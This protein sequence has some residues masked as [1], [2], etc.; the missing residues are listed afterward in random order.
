MATIPKGSA[1]LSLDNAVKFY[2]TQVETGSV[3]S[4]HACAARFGVNQEMLRQCITGRKSRSYDMSWF[5]AEDQILIKFFIEIAESGFPDTKQYLRERI[6]TLLRVK[7]GDPTFS[8][9]VNWVDRWLG[10]HKDQLQK[11]WNTSL[12][13]HRAN[14]VNPTTITDYFSKLQK[15]LNEH[16]IEPDCLWSMDETGL[17]FNHTPKKRVIGQAGKHQQHSIRHGSREFATIIPLISAAGACP[18]PTVIFQGVRMNTTWT[19][20]GNP[21]N[22]A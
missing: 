9:G 8:I 18:P 3:I 20:Q 15:V 21:L 1:E 14:A 2:T 5:M 12:D 11:Y 4:Y 22:A 10:R 17:Q 19:G 7:K 13:R 6:N 16:A